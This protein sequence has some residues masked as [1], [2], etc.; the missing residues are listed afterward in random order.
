MGDFW[1]IITKRWRQ[2]PV[3]FIMTPE[4]VRRF[5]H[6]GERT[7][8]LQANKYYTDKYRENWDRIGRGDLSAPPLSGKGREYSETLP[9]LKSPAKI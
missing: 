7:V 4:E 2:Q 3:C 8:W 6:R 9:R 5:A 1:I